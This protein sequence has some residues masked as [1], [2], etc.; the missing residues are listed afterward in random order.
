MCTL[1]HFILMY[2][3]DLYL[4]TIFEKLIRST[5]NLSTFLPVEILLLVFASIF[6]FSLIP[7]FTT[8]FF[9]LA[10]FS[11]ESISLS[12]SALIKRIFLFIA[13]EI[14][15]FVFPTPEKQFYLV[16]FQPSRQLITL[17]LTQHQHQYYFS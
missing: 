10:I 17:L 1:K 6:G 12:D 2:L 5:P 3:E 11:I 16:I 7:I 9:F 14:S 8:F 4:F 13:I 15:S